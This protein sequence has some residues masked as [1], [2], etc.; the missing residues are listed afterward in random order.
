MCVRNCG[1]RT[2]LVKKGEI[3]LE[4]LKSITFMG[5]NNNN[6]NNE[7]LQPNI[8]STNSPAFYL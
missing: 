7:T 5:E 1:G 2:V 8:F 3:R 6:E 4:V